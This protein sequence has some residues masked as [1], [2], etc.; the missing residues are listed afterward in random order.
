MV[1]K[2]IKQESESVNL[3][4]SLIAPILNAIS[5]YKEVCWVVQTLSLVSF[6]IDI[7]IS[8]FFLII[9]FKTLFIK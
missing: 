2:A 1:D 3:M 4:W 6:G 9:K 5:N 7:F 8:K